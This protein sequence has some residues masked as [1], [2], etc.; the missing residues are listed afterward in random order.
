MPTSSPHRTSRRLVGPALGGLGLLVLCGASPAPEGNETTMAVGMG[1]YEYRSGG[2]GGTRR[3][4][5][6]SEPLAQLQVRHRTDRDA[7]IVGESSLAVGRLGESRED[8]DEVDFEDDLLDDGQ[9]FWTGMAAVRFGRQ[10]RR[11][12]FELGPGVAYHRRLGGWTP[13]PSGGVWF[14]KPEAAYLWADVFRGPFS[15]ALEFAALAGVGHQSRRV[16][17]QVGSNTR[18]HVANLDFTVGQGVRLGFHAGYG[19]SWADQVT[20][21]LRG[22]VRLTIDYRAFSRPDP[23]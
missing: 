11:A 10:G 3:R 14:G 8:P 2:C 13:I 15:G 21:D 9:T 17:V 20:P 22:M 18:A 12:G 1:T 4:Y 16:A 5:S 6:V 7:L 23:P 19:E